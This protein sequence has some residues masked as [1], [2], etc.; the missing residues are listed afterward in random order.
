MGGGG[1]CK[2]SLRGCTQFIKR[3]HAV[4]LTFTQCGML[5]RWGGGGC[6]FINI[7][8]MWHNEED[9]GGGGGTQLLH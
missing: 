6:S 1:G 3:V 8:T 4:S 7:Y 5:K 9:W 2:V